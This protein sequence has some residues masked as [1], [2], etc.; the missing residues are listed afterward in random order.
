MTDRRPLSAGMNAMPNTSPDEVRMFVNQERRPQFPEPRELTLVAEVE[1]ELES[2]K[3]T[4]TE[5]PRIRRRVKSAGVNPV[6]LIPIT[7]RLRPQVAGALKR[8]SLERQLS[9]EEPSAQQD[10]VECV[11]EPWLRTNGFLS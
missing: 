11:L 10:I 1:P 8:A 3:P 6:G 9:G 2:P 7:V 5:R 4:S